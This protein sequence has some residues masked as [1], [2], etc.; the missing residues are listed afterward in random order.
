MQSFCHFAPP[1]S[2]FWGFS[3]FLVQLLTGCNGKTDIRD[4]YFPLKK[5]ETPKVY[6][7]RAVESD[8]LPPLYRYYRTIVS[9][10]KIYFTEN[11]YDGN[12]NVTQFSREERLADGMVLRDKIIYFPAPGG[13]SMVIK[14][15]IEA[16]AMFPFVVTDSNGVFVYNIAFDNPT[17][18]SSMRLIR[19]RRFIKKTNYV[20]EGK[21]YNAVEFDIK[22]ADEYEKQGTL[23]LDSHIREIYAEGI[24]LVETRQTY[25][26]Y[27]PVSYRLKAI[28]DME[29]LETE[30][31]AKAK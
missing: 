24:G 14:T 25:A 17:D 19:N 3:F 9:D 20:W 26:G 10:E 16:A 31:K 21:T 15:K 5:L 7:Y 4:F 30:L 13:K 11:T 28:Y 8:S 12:L 1:P 27:P 29:V 6:E 23:R 2:I 18:T 22:V